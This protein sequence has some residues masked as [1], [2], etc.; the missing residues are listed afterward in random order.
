MLLTAKSLV[1]WRSSRTRSNGSSGPVIFALIASRAWRFLSS[2]WAFEGSG[3][4][5]REMAV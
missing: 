2:K 4:L 1:A 5:V 3:G